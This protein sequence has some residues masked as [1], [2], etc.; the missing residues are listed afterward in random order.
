MRTQSRAN[1][2]FLMYQQR[3]PKGTITQKIHVLFPSD[4]IRSNSFQGSG[5]LR[6]EISG[7]HAAKFAIRQILQAVL[8]GLEHQFIK[9]QRLVVVFKI[10]VK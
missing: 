6:N 2:L 5:H 7:K 1:G 10:I 9:I 4:L 3:L 8:H